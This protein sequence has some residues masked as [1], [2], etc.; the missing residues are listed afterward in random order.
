MKKIDPSKMQKDMEHSFKAYIDGKKQS[1]KIT[2]KYR[3][4]FKEDHFKIKIDKE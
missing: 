2:D 3:K 4:Y 1:E